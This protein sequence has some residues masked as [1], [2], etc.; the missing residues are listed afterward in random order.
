MTGMA[1]E[2]RRTTEDC[3]TVVTLVSK[4]SWALSPSFVIMKWR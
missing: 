2:L 1:R 4:L 3:C